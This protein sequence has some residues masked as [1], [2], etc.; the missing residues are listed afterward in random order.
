M[1][2]QGEFEEE[3]GRDVKEGKVSNDGGLVVKEKL[4]GETHSLVHA[5]LSKQPCEEQ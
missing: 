3:L 2:Q 4:E 1:V 5:G